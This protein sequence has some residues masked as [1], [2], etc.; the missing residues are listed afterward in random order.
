LELINI[1][2]QEPCAKEKPRMKYLWWYFQPEAI[3]LIYSLFG[4]IF[5]QPGLIRMPNHI[6]HNRI[7]FHIIRILQFQ[8]GDI[9]KVS[10]R[11]LVRK[12][13]DIN[14]FCT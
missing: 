10:A 6:F 14:L 13:V 9:S 12:D 11:P 4:K 2:H 8:V 3:V 7:H 5:F 1:L